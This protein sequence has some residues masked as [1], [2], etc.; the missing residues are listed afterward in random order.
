MDIS[1]NHDTAETWSGRSNYWLAHNE[2]R[3]PRKKREQS[4]RPLILAGHGVSLRV[5]GGSLCIRN[6]R[7]HFPQAPEVY[8]FFPGSREI[9]PRI[10]MLDGSGSISFDVL[11]WLAEQ[12]VALVRLN[13]RGD[14]VTVAGATGYAAIA[15]NVQWQRDTR[16]DARRRLVFSIALIRQKLEASTA[17]LTGALEDSPQRRLALAGVAKALEQFDR[18][19]VDLDRLRGIEGVTAAAYFNAWRGLEIKIRASPKRPIPEA[20]RQFDCRSSLANGLKPKNRNASDPINA[21]LN[22]AYGVLQAQVQVRA[23]SEGFDPTIGIMHHGFKDSPAYVFDLMEPERPKVDAAILSF[24]TACE[25]S[26]ADFTLRSDGVVRLS[27]QL[28]RRVC[29][30]VH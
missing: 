8:R 27:P 12:Q 11:A 9:P 23:V 2:L 1:L 26:A 5:E 30:L 21:M 6:G 4:K 10:I 15:K 14:V 22:Y 24:V 19:P 20:W 16:A 25:F 17:T 13:W 29:A 18:T 7:T 28:A 3:V